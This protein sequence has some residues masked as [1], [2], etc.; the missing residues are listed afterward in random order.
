MEKIKEL[1]LS[2]GKSHIFHMLLRLY[3]KSQ[4]Q[5][6]G[7]NKMLNMEIQLAYQKPVN[8]KICSFDYNLELFQIT[9]TLVHIENKY[10]DQIA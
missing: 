9:K 5:K 8:C 2:M 7:Q 3:D 1:V 6:Q 10:L 4:K